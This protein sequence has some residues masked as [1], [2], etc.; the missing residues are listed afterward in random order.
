MTEASD[1]ETGYLLESVTFPVQSAVAEEST[2]DD[3][4][5]DFR[6]GWDWRW[7]DRNRFEVGII[8]GLDPV[9]SRPQRVEVAVA[10]RFVVRG[11]A[12]T[13]P[14]ET[15]AHSHAPALL[16]PYLRQVV[17]EL[18]ARGPCSRILLPPTNIAALMQ[19]VPAETGTGVR[20]GRPG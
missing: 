12:Q 16:F 10:G 13:V 5:D 19:S 9:A 11:E 20:Q 2:A 3:P 15:F 8:F 4:G 7:L 6:W 1:T 14:P 17:D 18:T